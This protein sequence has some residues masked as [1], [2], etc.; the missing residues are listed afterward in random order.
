MSRKWE[1]LDRNA[2]YSIKNRLKHSCRVILHPN[3]FR[4]LGGVT[5]KQILWI[6]EKSDVETR[7]MGTWALSSFEVGVHS[8]SMWLWLNKLHAGTAFA[9][10]CWQCYTYGWL[11]V[12]DSAI[13]MDGVD[14][15]NWLRGDIGRT[16]GASSLRRSLTLVPFYTDT[17][18]WGELCSPG[19]NRTVGSLTQPCNLLGLIVSQ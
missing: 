13:H 17:Y 6:S 8:M 19:G 11:H 1:L 2:I 4:K 7:T 15:V 18:I 12:I 16:S 10:C 5:V 9:P 14:I 3:P